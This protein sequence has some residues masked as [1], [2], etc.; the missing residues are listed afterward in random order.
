MG[1]SYVVRVSEIIF[2]SQLKIGKETGTEREAVTEVER[3]RNGQTE[4]E[5]RPQT[6]TQSQL[7]NNQ[8]HSMTISNSKIITS[9]SNSNTRHSYSPSLFVLS[10]YGH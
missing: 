7:Q 10:G 8:V 3:E 1:M 4:T 5:S 9:V 2:S 6:Q